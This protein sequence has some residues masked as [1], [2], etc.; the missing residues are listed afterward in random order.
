M[1]PSRRPA[2]PRAWFL[3]VGPNV[4]GALIDLY[5]SVVY[6]ITVRN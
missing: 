1:V 3:R 2:F 5:I 4:A 6:L